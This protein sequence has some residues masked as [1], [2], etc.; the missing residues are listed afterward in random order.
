MRERTTARRRDEILLGAKKRDS[1]L[2]TDL[3]CC[4]CV[5]FVFYCVLSPDYLS[6][7]LPF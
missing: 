6:P 4:V 3:V 1:A 2:V 7:P 5:V